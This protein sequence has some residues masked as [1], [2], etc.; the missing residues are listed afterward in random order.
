M[1]I[2]RSCGAAF[3]FEWAVASCVCW[4]RG[5]VGVAYPSGFNPGG[6]RGVRLVVVR[7][8]HEGEDASLLGAIAAF[9]LGLVEGLI[10]GFD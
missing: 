5:V 3:E 1:S 8:G 9:L 10:R 2:V 6:S 4:R 7:V